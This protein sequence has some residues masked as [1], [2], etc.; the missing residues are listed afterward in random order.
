MVADAEWQR[1]RAGLR[2]GQVFQGTVVRV[3]SPGAIGVF[4]DIG[5][6]VEGFVDGLLL[7]DLPERW[8]AEGT[9]SD[10][11]IWWADERRQIRLKPVGPRYLREDFEEFADRI[12][13]G[14]ADAIGRPVDEGRT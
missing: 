4:V 11:E 8:P 1:I 9:V 3:P 6:P 12:A 13:P 10:F 7:P 2:F 14:W 5:L